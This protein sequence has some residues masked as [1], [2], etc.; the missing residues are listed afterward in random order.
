[1]DSWGLS[2]DS[3]ARVAVLLALGSH[4]VRHS[5]ETMDKP[6]TVILQVLSRPDTGWHRFF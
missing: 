3:A 4:K 6:D 2:Y 5:D 1:L